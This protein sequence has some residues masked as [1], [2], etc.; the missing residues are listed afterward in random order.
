M[1]G[2]CQQWSARPRR[3]TL[4]FQTFKF[5][6]N[7]CMC[8]GLRQKCEHKNSGLDVGFR[9]GITDFTLVSLDHW[10]SGPCWPASFEHPHKGSACQIW[11]KWLVYDLFGIAWCHVLSFEYWDIY[12]IFAHILS[13]KPILEKRK[14]HILYTSTNPSLRHFLTLG[15]L[16]ISLVAS[17]LVPVGPI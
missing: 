6:W 9:C 10:S 8:L 7:N 2:P 5:K 15:Y 12:G 4:A 1:I 11:L 13:M 16:N 17:F 3:L 14:S